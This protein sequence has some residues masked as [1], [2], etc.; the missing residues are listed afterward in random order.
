MAEVP[1]RRHPR[2]PGHRSSVIRWHAT[3]DMERPG[4]WRLY[5][6]ERQMGEL[7]LS[8][9][10][11]S[12]AEHAAYRLMVEDAMLL[13]NNVGIADHLWALADMEEF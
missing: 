11:G 7:R 4:R 9:P 8:V 3:E 12:V 2:D 6:G 5:R 13:W 1:Y 10:F